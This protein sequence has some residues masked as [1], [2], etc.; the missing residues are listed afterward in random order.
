[1]LN[2]GKAVYLA[3][4]VAAGII[5]IGPFTCMNGIVSEAIYPRISRHPSGTPSVVSTSTARNRT[6]TATWE[7]TWNWR[8]ATGADWAEVGVRTCVTEPRARRR[9]KV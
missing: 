2:V 1:M 8:A 9:I 4:N 7:C 3:R 5:D 6:L